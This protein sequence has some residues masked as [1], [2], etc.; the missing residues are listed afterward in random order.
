MTFKVWK[1]KIV[2]FKTQSSMNENQK[3]ILILESLKKNTER[4]DLKDWV[5]Q[6]IDEDITLDMNQED[7]ISKLIEKMEGK[8][9]ISKWK[10]TGEIWE[11]LVKFQMKEDKT[12]KQ[13]LSRF[14]QLES[15][16]KNAKMTILPQYL[17]HHFLDR[18]NLDHLTIRSILAM[19]NLYNE[20]EILK[21]I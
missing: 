9:E 12:P 13:Y 15:E 3:L 4:Q 1:Q 7:V 19:A 5:I 17:G 18:A 20:E 2:N 11:E 8:F 6:Q 14:K 21:Q 10:K 16:I